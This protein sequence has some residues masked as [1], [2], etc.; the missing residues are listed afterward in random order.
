MVKPTLADYDVALR[1]HLPELSDASRQR[2][3][4]ALFQG[5]VGSLDLLDHIEDEAR[6][7]A[8][9]RADTDA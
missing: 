4:L 8:I 1:I 3:A 9:R 2:I 6:E 7:R 5:H